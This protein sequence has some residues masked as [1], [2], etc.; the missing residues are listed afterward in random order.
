[1]ESG[2]GKRLKSLIRKQIRRS[3]ISCSSQT[4]KRLSSSS[5]VLQENKLECLPL[6]TRFFPSLFVLQENKLVFD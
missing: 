5:I 3:L 1:V 2:I 4:K 6:N